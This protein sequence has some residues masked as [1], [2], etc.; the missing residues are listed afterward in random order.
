MFTSLILWINFAFSIVV[1]ENEK[2]WADMKYMRVFGSTYSSVYWLDISK[3]DKDLST[4]YKTMLFYLKNVKDFPVSINIWTKVN[5][6]EV[7]K[8]LVELKNIINSR[9]EKLDDFEIYMSIE[10]FT[11]ENI[12]TISEIK[13]VK[14]H[15]GVIAYSDSIKNRY[16][17]IKI[18]SKNFEK[19][20]KNIAETIEFDSPN[21]HF[22][23]NWICSDF[24]KNFEWKTDKISCWWGF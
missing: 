16:K 7:W 10:N 8:F 24:Y 11:D 2:M 22:S 21:E 17:K 4:D 20:N 3:V 14:N 13:N 23:E 18:S 19:L 9:K 12:N 6:K 5:K 15:I 1:N